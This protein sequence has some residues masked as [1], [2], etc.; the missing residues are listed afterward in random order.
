MA[1]IYDKWFDK[2]WRELKKIVKNKMKEKVI[3]Y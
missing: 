2:K 1:D 3:I